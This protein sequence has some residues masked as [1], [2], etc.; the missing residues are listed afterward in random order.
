MTTAP[1]GRERFRSDLDYIVALCD[2]MLHT[3]EAMSAPLA[4][5]VARPAPTPPDD[6]D[7]ADDS[8]ADTSVLV[9]A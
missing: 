6:D 5:V 2:G 7:Y 4:E 8:D 3:A 9:G 1:P